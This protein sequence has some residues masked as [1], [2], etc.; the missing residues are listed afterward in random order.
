M[1]SEVLEKL[2]TK[3]DVDVLRGHLD[4][5]V[6]SLYSSDGKKKA[7]EINERLGVGMA[8]VLDGI[9]PAGDRDRE[10]LLR[11]LQTELGEVRVLELVLSFDP[12][13]RVIDE[14]CVWVKKNLGTDVVVDISVDRR[15]AGGV[16]LTY[17]GVYRD[18]SLK[19][20]LSEWFSR[21]GRKVGEILAK[22]GNQRRTI[23]H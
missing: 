10:E 7:I 14:I 6:S 19:K 4:I 9:L 5:L 18:L 2:K 15:I 12:P 3:E 8:K 1:Y 16:K 13:G 21:N 11:K 23:N 20:S 22:P 17:E